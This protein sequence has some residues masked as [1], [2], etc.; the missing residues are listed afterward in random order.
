MGLFECN[1]MPFGLQNAPATFQRLMQTCLE[2]QNYS[3]VLLYLDDIIV[4]S[5]TFEEHIQRLEKVFTCLRQ[6][7]LK[8]KPSKCHLLKKTSE[9]FRPHCVCIRNSHR[10]PTKFPRSTTGRHLAIAKKYFDF[11]ASLA[12]IDDTSKD[13]PTS[14]HQ[15]TNSQL[16]TR[17]E[18]RKA[19]TD[20]LHQFHPSS[21]QMNSRSH[22][23][24]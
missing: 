19:R 22:L 6:H 3:T 7:G 2:D 12:I 15:C 9:I 8:L 20:I 16:E 14:Y 4:F 5:S 11:L 18:G 17:N 10:S 21:G 13:T 1:R 24:H 23:K